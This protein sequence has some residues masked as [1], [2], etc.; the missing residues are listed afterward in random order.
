[1]RQ[2]AI[3]AALLLTV[4]TTL[5]AQGNPTI[6]FGNGAWLYDGTYSSSGE[7]Q[8]PKAGLF[9]N[10]LT[11]YNNTAT[12]G[13]RITQPFAYGGDIEMYCQ[14]SG[15]S[16][17]GDAC[18][19]NNLL[20]IYYPAGTISK[21]KNDW[22]YFPAVLGDSGY[23]S[24]QQYSHV[25][26]VKNNVAVIDGRVDN[27]ITGIYDYLDHLNTLGKT[28]AEH[29][30]DKVAYTLCA[31]DSLRGIQFDIEPFS[32][33][34]KGGT[35][36][37]TGQKYFYDQIA[38]DF[39]GYHD[40]D[41]SND[42]F[43]CV[44]KK[45][46]DGRFFSVFTFSKSITP[47]VA[48]TLTKYHNGM[49]VDS[50]YDLGEKPG[51]SYNTVAEFKALAA[52][53]IADMQAISQQYNLAYQFAIPVSASAHEFETKAGVSTGQKQ[54][55]Y[56]TAAIEAIQPDQLKQSDP[57]FKGVDVWAWNQAMWWGGNQYTPSK[58]SNAVLDYLKNTL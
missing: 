36:A 7:K 4:P 10:S 40:G 34:G 53:E 46:P 56:V 45:N 9:V 22:G 18:S 16:Q 17:V 30:A 48:A 39:A 44:D 38:K 49:V 28:D 20:V 50:L 8:P 52:K 27:G 23:A 35:F 15:E 3:A 37:G 41:S 13:H 51:G 5:F 29:F 11:A 1:M 21:S 2:Y 47:E 54:M 24:V 26:Y 55:D 32:F 19:P 43:H 6:P 12:E 33:T 58:P 14:G 25:P 31:D 42:S 57:N